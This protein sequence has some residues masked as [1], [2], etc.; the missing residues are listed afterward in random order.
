[1]I[2]AKWSAEKLAP[3]SL[4][5]VIRDEHGEVL[6]IVHPV[7]RDHERRADFLAH[8]LAAPDLLEA[9]ESAIEFIPT[10]GDR[11]ARAI[12]AVEVARRRPGLGP[13]PTRKA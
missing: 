11:R 5:Y 8:V 7:G 13:V 4:A 9:L 1:M 6:G 2:P 3:D 10:S 12:A